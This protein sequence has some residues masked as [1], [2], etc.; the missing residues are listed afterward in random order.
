VRDGG[1]RGLFLIVCA[2]FGVFATAEVSTNA[3][4]VRSQNDAHAI[5]DLNETIRIAC[6]RF[7]LASSVHYDACLKREREAAVEYPLPDLGA[8]RPSDAFTARVACMPSRLVG[9]DAFHRCLAKEV[10]DAIA[11]PSPDPKDQDTESLREGYVAC[12]NARPLGNLAYNGC[13]SRF[14][15]IPTK[16]AGDSD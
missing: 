7:R 8:L 5:P 12:R 16:S 1:R 10:A 6:Y 4:G 15:R 11:H 2:F 13:L 14:V 9:V 3:Q